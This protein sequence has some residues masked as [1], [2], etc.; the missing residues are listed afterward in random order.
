MLPPQVKTQTRWSL[1]I[2]AYAVIFCGHEVEYV[3]FLTLL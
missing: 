1:N 2:C 3:D